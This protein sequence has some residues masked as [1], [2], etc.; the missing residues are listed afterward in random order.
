M[1]STDQEALE[2]SWK[3]FNAGVEEMRIRAANLGKDSA[4]RALFIRL[5]RAIELAAELCSI[6]P[7]AAE[8][9]RRTLQT[10]LEEK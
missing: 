1:H 10:L 2:R 3:N 5:A 4:E 9:I 7:K 8:E 6:D